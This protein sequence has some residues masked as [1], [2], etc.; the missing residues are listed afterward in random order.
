VSEIT[1]SLKTPKEETAWRPTRK[2]EDNI[3]MDFGE[4]FNEKFD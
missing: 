3:K 2:C 1:S 4:T